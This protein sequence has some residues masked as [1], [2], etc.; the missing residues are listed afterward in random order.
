MADMSVKSGS[1]RHARRY[2][3]PALSARA[4][5][6]YVSLS[7][8][9]AGFFV[10]ISALKIAPMRWLSFISFPRSALRPGPLMQLCRG[11]MACRR[12]IACT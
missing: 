9:T 10:R 3:V 6:R 1:S 7:L 5:C 11:H 12:H 4:L 8:L 2:Q